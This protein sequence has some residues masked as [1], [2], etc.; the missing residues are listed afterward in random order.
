[1]LSLFL[2][3]FWSTTEEMKDLKTKAVKI[4]LFAPILGFIELITFPLAIFGYALWFVICNGKCL[5]Y[6]KPKPCFNFLIFFLVFEVPPYAVVSFEDSAKSNPNSKYTFVS[7]NLLLG[8]ESLGKFQNMPFVYDRLSQI[9]HSFSHINQ[10][11][12]AERIGNA[13][14]LEDARIGDEELMDTSVSARWPFV[15]FMCF[16]E[17][18]D[19]YFA[20]KLIRSL[21]PEF[22]HFVVDVAKHGWQSNMYFGSEYSMSGIR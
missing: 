8:I 6:K 2:S 7:A 12:E 10:D 5:I 18:W 1:M 15:D 21:H 4:L 17:V 14:I 13:P 22:K 20:A 19:R 11:S 3:C 9:C 16:Q